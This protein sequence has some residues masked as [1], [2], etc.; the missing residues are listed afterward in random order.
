[1]RESALAHIGKRLALRFGRLAWPLSLAVSIAILAHW[2]LYLAAYM[3]P[4]IRAEYLHELWSLA[5]A[6]EQGRV[7]EV[8]GFVLRPVGGHIIAYSRL[9]SLANW[10]LFDYEGSVT[11]LAAIATY[12]ACG[13]SLLY[14][15]ASAGRSGFAAGVTLIA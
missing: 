5:P 1:M 7:L 15:V 12:V 11:K 6:L 14:A 10:V 9:V 4:I 2:V 3:P 13:L 8:V